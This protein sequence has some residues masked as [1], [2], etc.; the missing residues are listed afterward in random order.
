MKIAVC[1][2][3]L[4]YINI[5]ENNLYDLTAKIECDAFQSGEELIAAYKN[6]IERYDVIFLDME[7]NR[8]NGIETANIIREFDEYVIIVFVT[9][10][11][12]YMRESFKCSPF[13]FL[14][15]PVDAE[16]LKSVFGDIC[17]KLSKKRNV[18]NFIE[19][20]SPVRLYCN[21]IIYCECQAHWIYIHTKDEV[22]K[23]CKSMAEF[24]NMLD[25][26]IL[27]RVHASFII[28]FLYVKTIKGDHAQLYHCEEKIPISRSYR[29]K[30]L[31]E[32]TNFI[33]RNLYI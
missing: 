14:L 29:K 30:T 1:D 25:K 8:L 12:E 33:E 2:D 18:L 20:K 6:N 24:Y 17:K 3:N 4:E 31:A 23:I 21:D 19:N 16:E 32:Y 9:S 5:I 27:Y 22:Y 15:K 10:H 11:T 26:D 13:R 7:M 28:N